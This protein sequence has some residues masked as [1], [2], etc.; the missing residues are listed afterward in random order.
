MRTRTF[1]I[2]GLTLAILLG[3]AGAIYAYDNSRGDTIAKGVTVGGLDIGGLSVAQ[4]HRR[5]ETQYLAALRRP[6][7]IHHDTSTWTLGAREARIEA[8][9]DEVLS[10]ALTRS[11]QGNILSRTWRRLTGGTVDTTLDPQV[12]YS[13]AAVLRMLDKVRRAI[14]RKPTDAS[15]SISLAGFKKVDSRDG[16]EVDRHTLHQ[17]IDAAI[18]STTAKRTF[19]AKT[20]HHKPKVTTGRLAKQSGTI[21]IVNKS[22]FSVKI[23]KNL[24]FEK[25]YPIAIGAPGHDTPEGTFHIQ[26]KQ[27]DPVWSVPNSPWAGELAGTTVEGGTAANPLKARWLGVTDGVGFHGTSD[28][29]SIGSAASHGCMR[30]HVSDVIDMYPRVPVG[31]TVYISH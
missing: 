25:A 27:I 21:L 23:Y 16:L 18:V 3:G 22:T 8:N 5:L 28:D 6:I 15:L 19:V 1:I 9:I 29:A 11:G 10:E 4:A 14:D 12:T 13:D 24:K 26:G 7:V 2:V 20:I 30:M 17:Q 31:A